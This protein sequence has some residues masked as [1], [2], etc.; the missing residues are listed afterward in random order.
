VPPERANLKS[1]LCRKIAPRAFATVEEMHPKPPD[2][3]ASQRD[4]I[5]AEAA[6]FLESLQS[7][8]PMGVGSVDRSFRY[9]RW[10]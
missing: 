5:D 9:V 8:A 3:E 10:S 6:A 4:A 1:S 7:S 2:S